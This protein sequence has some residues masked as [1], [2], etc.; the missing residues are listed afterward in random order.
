[1]GVPK[2]MGERQSLISLLQTS[3]CLKIN[4]EGYENTNMREG[5]DMA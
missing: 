2:F 3:Q 4:V 1:M 5:G